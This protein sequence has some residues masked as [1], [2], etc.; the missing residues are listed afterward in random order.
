[1]RQVND[2]LLV[3]GGPKAWELTRV[4]PDRDATRA[5]GGLKSHIG[6]TI[7]DIDPVHVQSERSLVM[8]VIVNIVRDVPACALR[9]GIALSHL[10]VVE[11][12]IVLILDLHRRSKRCVSHAS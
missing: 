3:N 4:D 1:M 9:H 5:S 12:Y 2:P 6:P 10:Q 11:S 7:T 8:I